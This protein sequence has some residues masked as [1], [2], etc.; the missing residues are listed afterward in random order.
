VS[1]TQVVTKREAD[2]ATVYDFQCPYPTGC[3]N[4]TADPESRFTSLGW[5]DREHARERARQHIAEHQG[6][7]IT[8]DLHTFRVERGITTPPPTPNPDDWDI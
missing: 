8:Q 6:E 2:G 3:G 5:A 7:D 4:D 1:K